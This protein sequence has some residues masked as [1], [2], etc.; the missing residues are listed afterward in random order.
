MSDTAPTGAA[1]LNATSISIRALSKFTAGAIKADD[2]HFDLTGS[3]P[4]ANIAVVESLMNA[5]PAEISTTITNTNVK[6]ANVRDPEIKRDEASLPQ[7]VSS[8]SQDEPTAP[9]ATPALTPAAPS[10]PALAEEKIVRLRVK[11][12]SLAPLTAQPARTAARLANRGAQQCAQ[13]LE[14]ILASSTIDFTNTGTKLKPNSEKS[15]EP[16]AA[17]LI[18]C[19][20]LSI[21]IAG[22]SNLHR[23]NRRNRHL[24]QQRANAVEDYLQNQGV[25]ANRLTAIGWG[26]E[27][28]KAQR[29]IRTA[30]Q[31]FD[32]IEFEIRIIEKQTETAENDTSP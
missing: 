22:H 3:I 7:D 5:M 13:R 24:S 2:D 11:T 20:D 4:A 15:L 21:V 17:I 14:K 19:P 30:D 1:W 6:V 10:P 31:K 12:P 8:L 9:I 28:I 25:P 32:S 18:D 26:N 23:S 16:A 29:T 27:V